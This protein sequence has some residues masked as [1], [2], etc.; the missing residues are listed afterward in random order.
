M[1]APIA[2]FLNHPDDDIVLFFVRQENIF[3]CVVPNC[4]LHEVRH[5]GERLARATNAEYT[6]HTKSVGQWNRF[7]ERNIDP[8]DVVLQDLIEHEL[9]GDD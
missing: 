3:P 6:G 1:K 4:S 2:R 7:V 8:C 9:S 5:H